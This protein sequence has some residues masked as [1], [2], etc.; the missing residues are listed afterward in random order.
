MN[1]K[2]I[3]SLISLINRLHK[4][5]YPVLVIIIIVGLSFLASHKNFFLAPHECEVLKIYDGDTMT[6]QCQGKSEKTRVRMYCI[7]TPEIK[8]KPWGIQ[9]RNHL[10]SITGKVVQLVEVEKDNYGRMVG[11]VYDGEINLNLAQVE[12]GQA[13]VYDAY[14]KKSE[15][16]V[17]ENQAKKAK[18]GIW[19][20]PGIQQKPWE[21]RKQQRTK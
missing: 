18:L 10:R 15:Y 4:Q 8:Q 7:D 3:K 17:A 14:C 12:M 1:K 2:Q 19:T 11:E 9:A 13:A 16:K 5:K 21:W 20:Q 6:L